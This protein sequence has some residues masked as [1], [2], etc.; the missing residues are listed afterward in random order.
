MKRISEM[1]LLPGVWASRFVRLFLLVAWLGTTHLGAAEKEKKQD[2]SP[3]VPHVIDSTIGERVANGRFNK[4]LEKQSVVFPHL[5]VRGALPQPKLFPAG[6]LPLRCPD[7]DLAIWDIASPKEPYASYLKN[8]DG[9]INK[10]HDQELINLCV[11]NGL[12]TAAEYELRRV[13]QRIGDFRKPGYRVYLKQWLRFADKRQVPYTFSLPVKGEWYVVR[14]TTGHHRIKHGAAY[15]L[16]LVIN[17]SGKSYR[18]S[19]RKLTDHY[20]WGKPIVAQADGVVMHVVDSFKDNPIG[21]FGGFHSANAVAVYYGASIMG[22][23]GHIQQGSAKVKV[24]QKVA[25]GDTLALVG[26][27]G[28][29]GLP[30]LHFTLTDT[31]SFSIKGRYSYERKEG[32]RWITMNG[33]ALIEGASVRNWEPRRKKKE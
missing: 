2:A 21:T 18:G 15:A 33:V 26:N 22:S 3:V 8:R 17:K 10:R 20:C 1:A 5:H 6:K 4:P 27:S 32:S 9:F 29:S 30:H 19:G 11:R 16:D 23:Y 12:S 13:L 31:G 28:A 24:G 25:R 7:F 14:D